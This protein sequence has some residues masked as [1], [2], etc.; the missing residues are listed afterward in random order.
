MNNCIVWFR[1]DL[2]LS[3]NPA[4]HQAV[5]QADQLTLV[6]IHAPEEMGSWAHGAASQWWLHHSL[7][8]LADDI[9]QRGGKLIVRHGNSLNQLL[10]IASTTASQHIFCNHLYEPAARKRDHQL[11]QQLAHHGITLHGWHG[12]L[13]YC[14]GSIM[15][16][17]QQPYRVFTPFWNR[18]LQQPVDGEPLPAAA[19][20]RTGPD[21]ASLNVSELELLPAIPWYQGFAKHH[22]PGEAG[23]WKQWQTFTQHAVHHYASQRDIPAINGTSRLSAHLHF[24]EI[25]PRQLL[26]LNQGIHSAGIEGFRRELGW[27]EFAYHLLHHFPETTRQS[28]DPRFSDF[29]WQQGLT[30]LLT[31]W[32]RGLTGIPMVDAGMRELWHTGVMHNRVRMITASLLTKNLGQHWLS[33][34]EWFWDTLVDADLAANTLNWQWVA[35]CGADAAPYFRIFNPV[36]QGKKFDP[37]GIYLRRWL[38]E[39]AALPNKYLHAPWTAPQHVCRGANVVLGDHYPAPIVDLAQSRE[40]ALARYG[41]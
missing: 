31:A 34:A 21:V 2:R 13:L 6:Y 38:P 30:P 32:Q 35:G 1:Q 28:L 8:A 39:L 26:Y 19:T 4:L 22:H 17:S 18:C 37:D 14:P 9:Q 29:P 5:T 11:A 24:G 20:Y 16:Q 36:L 25:S 7:T 40:Q 41:K 12:N 3:D 10:D 23:A 15:T 27:R 33:G